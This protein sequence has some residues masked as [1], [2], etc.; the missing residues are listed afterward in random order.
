MSIRPQSLSELLMK[1]ENDGFIIR[2]KN[3]QDK[4]ETLVSLTD[5]GKQRSKEFEALRK[6]QAA[7]F[8]APL[9]H[10]EREKLLNLLIKLIKIEEN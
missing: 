3:E 2:I 4:R 6:E 1:L 7:K 8:L 10:N 9:T 5:K